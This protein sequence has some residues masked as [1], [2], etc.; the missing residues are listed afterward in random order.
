MTKDHFN[1]QKLLDDSMISIIKKVLNIISSN[2]LPGDHHFYITF[3][4]NY[5]GVVVPLFLITKDHN[6]VTIVI[7][8]LF[9]DLEVN[10]NGFS[11]YLSFK[12]K[13][14]KLVIPFKAI[15]A[16]TDPSVNFALKLECDDIS[17]YTTDPRQCDNVSLKDSS[18]SAFGA[19][20]NNII[21]LSNFR[22]KTEQ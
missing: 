12:G 19:D 8:H 13:F 9:K 17:D 11:V 2:G 10:K 5:K 4:I 16:F 22:D 7:Q 14:E 3:D 6:K 20:K 1:Y 21:D 18:D 15:T